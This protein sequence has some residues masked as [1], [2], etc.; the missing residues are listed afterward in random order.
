MRPL[1]SSSKPLLQTSGEQPSGR[2]GPGDGLLGSIIVGS[3][4]IGS[5]L[6]GSSRTRPPASRTSLRPADLPRSQ[7][8]AE[9]TRPARQRLRAKRSAW[10][11]PT[12]KRKFRELY[13][14]VAI[15]F[16]KF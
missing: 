12:P 9:R 7:A 8:T 15:Q 4:L 14:G 6:L 11:I 1:Q 10:L 2:D 3:M 5:D 13:E 16:K